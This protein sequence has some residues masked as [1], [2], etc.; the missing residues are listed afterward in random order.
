MYMQ[1]AETFKFMEN[2]L[3]VY[4]DSAEFHIL[5]TSLRQ[6]KENSTFIFPISRNSSWAFQNE[7]EIKHIISTPEYPKHYP[8]TVIS[9]YS[10]SQHAKYDV[11]ERAARANYFNTKF[12]AWL[13]VGYFRERNSTN[14]FKLLL[15][16]DFEESRVAMNEIV[17]RRMNR[18]VRDIFLNNKVWLGGGLF[19]GE[20]SRLIVFAKQFKKSVAYFLSR[21][22]VNTDQQVV[23]AMYSEEGRK[24]LK[25]DVE[26]HVYH[27]S[28]WFSLGKAMLCEL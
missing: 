21:R 9:G 14:K 25:P 4:T 2:P 26:L 16:K 19:F 17:K 1:W 20:M 10:C 7:P 23:Y 8:N 28:G 22:L 12:M 6:G 3:V 13:D 24:S 27:F 18:R 5:M 15:L 11:I